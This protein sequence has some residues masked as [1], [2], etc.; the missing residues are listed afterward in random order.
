MVTKKDSAEKQKAKLV[1]EIILVMHGVNM[2]PQKE[3][4]TTLQRENRDRLERAS[5]PSE[6]KSIFIN[7]LESLKT[8]L[9]NKSIEELSKILKEERKIK[10]GLEAKQNDRHHAT[11]IEDEYKG[12]YQK[13]PSAV[14]AKEPINTGAQRER[15]H[16][17]RNL[18]YK[19]VWEKLLTENGLEYGWEGIVSA[20]PSIHYDKDRGE[21]LGTDEF[22]E[23]LSIKKKSFQNTFSKMK[24][25]LMY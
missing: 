20:I 9:E 23:P 14:P 5:D 15:R 18:I 12:A 21:I 8:R 2:N 24:K 10:V 11:I 19:L 7:Y 13:K 25:K 17:P 16:R 3:N 4:L 22:N 1:N 6:T